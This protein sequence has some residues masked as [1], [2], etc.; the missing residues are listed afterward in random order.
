MANSRSVKHIGLQGEWKPN[1]DSGLKMIK[2]IQL[3]KTVSNSG[4]CA[5]SMYVPTL[6]PNSSPGA[7]VMG[8]VVRFKSQREPMEV[9]TICTFGS[10]AKLA[11]AS[12]L[13]ETGFRFHGQMGFENDDNPQ[14]CVLISLGST[15]PNTKAKARVSRV[16]IRNG[17]G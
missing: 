6:K 11:E 15:L 4:P 16:K 1:L 9:F 17:D 5:T 10:R 12:I 7:R 13:R 14:K 8:F 3:I 2:K